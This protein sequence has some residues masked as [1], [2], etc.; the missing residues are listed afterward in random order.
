MR[1][2]LGFVCGV[3]LG[4]K[5]LIAGMLLGGFKVDFGSAWVGLELICAKCAARFCRG[6]WI[7]SGCGY[8]RPVWV[9]V[10]APSIGIIHYQLFSEKVFKSFDHGNGTN[11]HCPAYSGYLQCFAWDP[12]TD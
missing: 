8:L 7:A 12:L 5:G 4:G 2:G 10:M 1:A 6:F 9:M 11:F 3:D